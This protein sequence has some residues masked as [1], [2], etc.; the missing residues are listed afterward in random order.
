MALPSINDAARLSPPA[1]IPSKYPGSSN[2]LANGVAAGQAGEALPR[3]IPAATVRLDTKIRTKEHQNFIVRD[4]L[5][6]ELAGKNWTSVVTEYMAGFAYK[7]VDASQHTSVSPKLLVSKYSGA[8]DLVSLGEYI[9]LRPITLRQ[10]TY[11]INSE[12]DGS[13]SNSSVDEAIRQTPELK[14]RSVKDFGWEA[15]GDSKFQCRTAIGP[16]SGG[17]AF[18]MKELP[19]QPKNAP[20]HVQLRSHL[21]GKYTNLLKNQPFSFSWFFGNHTMEPTHVDFIKNDANWQGQEA[22]PEITAPIGPGGS[23]VVVM[24]A[25]PAIAPQVPYAEFYSKSERM[26]PAIEVTWGSS[27]SNVARKC[28]IIVRRSGQNISMWEENNGQWK[29]VEGK[30]SSPIT[31]N[32]EFVDICVYPVGRQIWVVPSMEIDANS[33]KLA[34]VFDFDHDVDVPAGKP[35]VSLYGGKQGFRWNHLFHVAKAVLLS[36]PMN[37]GIPT[38]ENAF[39]NLAYLGKDQVGRDEN[40]SPQDIS[41]LLIGTYQRDIPYGKAELL[42]QMVTFD[43]SFKYVLEYQL[44]ANKPNVDGICGRA[45]VTEQDGI[46]SQA[47]PNFPQDFQGG[48]EIG[49]YLKWLVVIYA[50][51]SKQNQETFKSPVLQRMELTAISPFTELNLNPRPQ[52]NAV[53]VMNVSISEAIGQIT[54]SVVLN[55]RNAPENNN[56]QG[57]FTYQYDKTNRVGS[58]NFVG[59]KPV[60]IRG[61]VIGGSHFVN[62][63]M[64]SYEGFGESKEPEN[65]DIPIRFRGYIVDR[66]YTRPNSSSSTVTL[67]CEDCSRRA[68]DHLTFNLPIFDGWCNIA[69]MYY[70]LRDSGY[71]DDEILLRQD[72]NNPKGSGTISLYQLLLEGGNDP[73]NFSGPCFSGHTKA[74]GGIPKA[75][76]LLTNAG[77]TIGMTTLHALLPLNVYKQQPNYMFSAGQNTWDCCSSIREF[78][79]FYLYANALGNIVYSPPEIQFKLSGKDAKPD[80]KSTAVRGTP[81]PDGN[82]I[83]YYETAQF[84]QGV[85]NG[86]AYNEFQ[87]QLNN[88]IKTEEMRNAVALFGLIPDSENNIMWSPHVAVKRPKNLIDDLAQ[89]WFAPWLRWAIVKN[90]NWNDG[91]RNEALAEE[92]F[93]RLRRTQ[94]TITFGL[95]GQPGHY[96]FQRFKIDEHQMNETG[97]HGLEFV[98]TQVTHNFDAAT[99]KFTTEI[100]GEHLDFSQFDFAPHVTGTPLR[101]YTGPGG[102]KGPQPHR[103]NVVTGHSRLNK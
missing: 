34:T 81:S 78:T 97:A 35:I 74:T 3:R 96:A 12:V 94:A 99:K 76:K 77:L 2:R 86:R 83:V 5:G 51:P 56:P 26:E 84:N 14:N 16:E 50:D 90:P 22:Q 31:V 82:N 70:L 57:K 49:N 11:C 68:K 80:E 15:Y 62:S 52:I 59:I 45:G 28:K 73:H 87:S 6:L 72:M 41:N 48:D 67:N 54:A 9:I 61:G 7:P 29:V 91:I 33:I 85:P 92:L 19:A 42:S 23:Q 47:I 44:L 39:V 79:G 100:T 4:L 30:R 38:I 71:D 32:K 53:D 66:Q 88:S 40:S 58:M 63:N 69:A 93:N 24:P 17:D 8:P 65:N 13:N 55:N 10:S 25:I 1:G 27:D 64:V 75:S 102:G 18:V 103:S 46:R 20:L 60:T 95:W 43:S 21:I 98:T 37:C 89:P 101:A 36:P